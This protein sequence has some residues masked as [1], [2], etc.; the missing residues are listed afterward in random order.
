MPT[1]KHALSYLILGQKGG[2][3]R[4][5][6]IDLL[7][8]RPYNLNQ[9]ADILNLNYRTV[10][11]H[12]DQLIKNELVSTSRTGGYGEV[13][14][15][16]PE[17]EG[18]IELFNDIVK[19]FTISKKLTSFRSSPKFF[20]S[21]MEQTHDA[22]III[23]DE[24]QVFFANDSA[25][26]LYGFTKNEISGQV[27]HIFPDEKLQ[28]DL[29]KKVTSGE[30]VTA[31][32][33]EL[34]HNSGK[35]IIVNLTMDAIKDENDKIIGFS[36]L[37]R[38]ITDHKIAEEA[39]A[40]SEERY[41]LAQRAANIGSWDWNI[42]TSELVWSDAI[43]PLFGFK[44]GEFEATYEA[45]LQC[46]H[47]DDRQYVIDSV[48]SCLEFGG[49]YAIE[50]RIVWP[51][52]TVRWVSENGDVIRDEN[53][54]PIRMLGIV[55]DI[56]ENKLNSENQ[57]LTI[58]I[59]EQLNQAG[60]GPDVI[61]GILDQIKDY[62][63]FEAV[64]IRLKKEN[65]YPYFVTKG[66]PGHFVE[67]EKYLCSKSKDGNMVIDSKG[68]PALECMCGNVIRGRT[69]PTLSFYT[70]GGS[71]FTNSTTKL[72]ATTTEEERMAKTRD[73]CNGEG[74]ESVALVPLHSGKEIVGLLQLNDSRP[75]LF[76]P[77]M[78]RFFEKIG[79]SIGIAFTGMAEDKRSRGNDVKYH[80]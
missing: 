16:T 26:K 21:V 67:A 49:D 33:T 5:Q 24:G 13:Y 75:N 38:D 47:A 25:E 54:K 9:M 78:I 61:Q 8:E 34:R 80:G 39:L 41:A 29:I 44:K 46:V 1:I 43:E 72:L 4:I 32:E 73:R 10:K 50:H 18:N 58:N 63:G 71:F 79:N 19:K 68:K 11:H 35:K 62:T 48:D 55:Q 28:D 20:R 40:L 77:S 27:L 14:F 56:T 3:N 70:P 66:F 15:L 37:S 17:M 42:I 69:D 60:G 45:F 59:L 7:K 22:V 53:G 65:D 51:D 74:Y 6:I 64:G 31:Y 76:S 23:N 36:L 52:G 2:Q 30:Q 57:E 12:I